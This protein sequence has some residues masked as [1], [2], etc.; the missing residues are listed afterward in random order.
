[1]SAT[2]RVVKQILVTHWSSR[3]LACARPRDDNPCRP[4]LL[5][6]GRSTPAL[7]RQRRLRL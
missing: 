5:E 7:H 3:S 2:W 4:R 6:R 1:M